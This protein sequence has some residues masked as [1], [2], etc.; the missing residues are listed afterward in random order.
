MIKNFKSTKNISILQKGS[1]YFVVRPKVTKQFLIGVKDEVQNFTMILHPHNSN[2]FIFLILGKKE[3]PRGKGRSYFAFI[4]KVYTNKQELLKE[5][6]EKHYNTK[7]KGERTLSAVQLLGY[8][9]YFIVKS[10]KHTELLYRLFFYPESKSS[11]IS[12]NIHEYDQFIIQV[13]NSKLPGFHNGNKPLLPERLQEAFIERKFIPLI[14]VDF[15]F[16]EGI[17]LLLNSRGKETFI[18][19]EPKMTEYLYKDSKENLLSYLA[20]KQSS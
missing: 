14:P 18:T 10:G 3:L 4:D 2:H 17:E 5:L 20:F 16:Y 7:T 15:I 9:K 11:Q 19:S 13:K 12:F 6:G 8:G 1:I